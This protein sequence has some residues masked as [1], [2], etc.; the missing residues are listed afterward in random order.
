M[1]PPCVRT[2]KGSTWQPPVG[3][4]ETE[5]ILR[6]SLVRKMEVI[7]TRKTRTP[8]GVVTERSARSRV[9]DCAALLADVKK[10]VGVINFPPGVVHTTV[11][12]RDPAV[13]AE[14]APE[15]RA[16]EPEPIHRT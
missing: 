3:R 4:A 11:A 15:M 6:P 16:E 9:I 12:G 10:M 5:A 8:T 1:G 14:K 7:S 13:A 2:Q